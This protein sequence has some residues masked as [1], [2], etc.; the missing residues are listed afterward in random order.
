VSV[1]RSFHIEIN[2]TSLF[3]K[4]RESYLGGPGECNKSRLIS[5]ICIPHDYT[6]E[7]N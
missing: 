7:K 4:V 1:N 3:I 5:Q 2:V 6:P